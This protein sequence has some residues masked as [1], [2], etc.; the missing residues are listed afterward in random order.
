MNIGKAFL[1]YLAVGAVLM[2]MGVPD[3]AGVGIAGIAFFV[4]LVVM[5]A[6]GKPTGKNG[7]QAKAKPASNNSYGH[8]ATMSEK[9]RRKEDDDLFD[10]L[11]ITGVFDED[12]F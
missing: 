5:A 8:Y 4:A 3:Y 11:M 2:L 6:T 9:Q 1:V 12:N 10:T 7:G